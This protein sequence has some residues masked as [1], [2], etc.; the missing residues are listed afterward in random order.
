M[1]FESKSSRRKKSSRSRRRRVHRTK[2][3][4][5]IAELKKPVMRAAET[6]ARHR[7]RKK[8]CRRALIGVSQGTIAVERQRARCLR[9]QCLGGDRPKDENET[10][11]GGSKHVQRIIS[12][13]VSYQQRGTSTADACRWHLTGEWELSS[14]SRHWRYSSRRHFD[15][16]SFPLSRR[17]RQIPLAEQSESSSLGPIAKQM[18]ISDSPPLQFATIRESSESTEMINLSRNTSPLIDICSGKAKVAIWRDSQFI[19]DGLTSTWNPMWSR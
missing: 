13:H 15:S 18:L 5:A 19:A 17:R 1:R 7:F 4:R 11:G 6:S 3:L 14:S 16:V 9:E 10:E 8:Y 12:D 2:G